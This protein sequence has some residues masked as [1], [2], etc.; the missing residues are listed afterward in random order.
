MKSKLLSSLIVK[1][2]VTCE[3]CLLDEMLKAVIIPVFLVA[4]APNACKIRCSTL[5]AQDQQQKL[6]NTKTTINTG[7]V[8]ISHSDIFLTTLGPLLPYQ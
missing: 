3:C 4:C 2:T 7:I 5:H 6:E 8:F 1:F